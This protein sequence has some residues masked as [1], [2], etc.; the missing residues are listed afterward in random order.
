MIWAHIFHAYLI[1]HTALL[2]EKGGGRGRSYCSPLY[3]IIYMPLCLLLYAIMNIAV[4]MLCVVERYVKDVENDLDFRH[5]C[6]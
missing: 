6:G 4:L 2:Y 5:I 3:V 1:A